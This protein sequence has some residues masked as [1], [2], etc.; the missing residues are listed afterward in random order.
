MS[1][2]NGESQNEILLSRGDFSGVASLAI[3]GQMTDNFNNYR[4]EI[5]GASGS[6][7]GEF[8]S[9][10]LRADSGAYF[11]TN[12]FYSGFH[13]NSVGFYVMNSGGDVNFLVGSLFGTNTAKT[14]NMILKINNARRLS[15]TGLIASAGQLSGA[16]AAYSSHRVGGQSSNSKISGIKL[17]AVTGIISGS[18]LLYGIRS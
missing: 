2:F 4:L 17:F 14:G 3:E 12:Y 1:G 7:D 6:S 18:Y 15:A 10:K 8:C 16:G 9:I 5:F 11:S 13:A